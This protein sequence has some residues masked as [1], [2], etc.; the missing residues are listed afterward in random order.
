MLIS[1]CG[2]MSTFGKYCDCNELDLQGIT[3]PLDAFGI[4]KQR[5]A[6]LFHPH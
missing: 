3:L 5:Q 1:E 6:I 2:R 4:E